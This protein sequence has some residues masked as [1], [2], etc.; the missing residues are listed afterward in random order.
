ML[1]NRERNAEILRRWRAGESTGWIADALALSRYTVENVVHYARKCGKNT[2]RVTG[3]RKRLR[4]PQQFLERNVDIVRLWR[5]GKSTSTI[6][7]ELGV[8][9]SLVAGIVYRARARGENVDHGARS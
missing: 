1:A 3:L 6:A 4:I 2:S 5:E 9:R 8:S 7:A